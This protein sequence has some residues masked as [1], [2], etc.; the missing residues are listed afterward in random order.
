MT[1]M[2]DDAEELKTYLLTW[3]GL[4]HVKEL[5]LIRHL[6]NPKRLLF[7]TTKGLC[8][9]DYRSCIR[10]PRHGGIEYESQKEKID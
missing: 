4:V 3:H 6:S 8:T 2:L 5:I 10:F 1:K 9:G 7:A